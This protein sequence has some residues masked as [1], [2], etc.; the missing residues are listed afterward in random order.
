MS[1]PAGNSDTAA[2]VQQSLGFSLGFRLST[3][4]ESDAAATRATGGGG[5]E[6]IKD[7]Y[8]YMY[9]CVLGCVCVCESVCVCVCV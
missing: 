8:M 7:T 5:E 1:K 6:G 3:A 4:G 9:E 2:P